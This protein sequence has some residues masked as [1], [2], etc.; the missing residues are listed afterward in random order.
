[1]IAPTRLVEASGPDGRDFNEAIAS[2]TTSDQDF[3]AAAGEDLERILRA[4]DQA[5]AP[6]GT[7]KS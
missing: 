1:M 2:I 4:L 6:G 3:C 5:A 7:P